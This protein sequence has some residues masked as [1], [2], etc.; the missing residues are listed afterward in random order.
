MVA[1]ALCLWLTPVPKLIRAVLLAALLLFLAQ[2]LLTLSR[3]GIY[4]AAISS[5]L[6]A[7]QLARSPRQRLNLILGAG[8][9]GLAC[10]L[11][12]VPAVEKL[13]GGAVSQRLKNTSGTGR[14]D[15]VQSELQIWANHPLLGVG[16]GMSFGERIRMGYGR[17]GSHTEYTRL[18][19][20]HGIPGVISFVLLFYMA[21][22]AF[23]SARTV[24]D[25][26]LAVSAASFGLLFMS[27]SALRLGLPALALGLACVRQVRPQTAFKPGQ[28]RRLANASGQSRSLAPLQWKF[29]AKNRIHG[30][31]T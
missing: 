6:G 20:E 4:L 12:V 5:A 15:I 28:M 7:V 2:A 25:K 26:V 23:G 16:V 24:Q 31:R 1:V 3:T 19:S 18:L 10:W 9:V 22:R 14:E 8:I 30:T 21:V 11:V 27:V 13:S 29:P 17:H